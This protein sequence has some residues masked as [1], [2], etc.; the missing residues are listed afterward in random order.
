MS[1]EP[2]LSKLTFKNN[3]FMRM[4]KL[5]LV[6]YPL[7]LTLETLD[8]ILLDQDKL[9]VAQSPA[10]QSDEAHVYRVVHSSVSDCS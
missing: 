6:G 4:Q 8:V 1:Q 3:F 7:P 9:L 5:R 2:I 10:A